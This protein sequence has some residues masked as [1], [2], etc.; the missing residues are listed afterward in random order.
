MDSTEQRITFDNLP[1]A[2]ATLLDKVQELKT[3]TEN[4]TTYGG[5]STWM[6][7]EEL[8]EYLPGHH[9]HSIRILFYRGRRGGRYSWHSCMCPPERLTRTDDPYYDSP[10]QWVQSHCRFSTELRPTLS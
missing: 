2:V 8:C 6:D 9:R 5:F 4:L 7:V 1:Q 10:I 3:L